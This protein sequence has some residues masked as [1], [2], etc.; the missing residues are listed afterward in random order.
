MLVISVPYIEPQPTY[1]PK[2]SESKYSRNRQ[3]KYEKKTG[4]NRTP[5]GKRRLPESEEANTKVGENERE[6]VKT[7]PP[8]ATVISASTVL[9]DIQSIAALNSYKSLSSTELILFLN[10]KSVRGI[11]FNY[12]IADF[13]NEHRAGS[14]SFRDFPEQPLVKYAYI[15]N[16]NTL[17][18]VFNDIMERTDAVVEFYTKGVDRIMSSDY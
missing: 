7:T 9:S 12:P 17:V 10:D 2:R 4:W 6:V 11:D 5:K 18:I 1:K 8:A 3:W 14:N 13:I 16:Y 15:E